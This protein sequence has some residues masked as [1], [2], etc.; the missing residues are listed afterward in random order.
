MRALNEQEIRGSLLN[1]SKREMAQASLPDLS[2]VAWEREIYLGWTDA[3]RPQESYVVFEDPES[4]ELLGA[5]LRAAPA[6][7]GR[8]KMMC[9][10]C[11]DITELDN[12]AFVSAKRTGAAGRS[13]STI[14]TSL[15]RDFSCSKNVRPLPSIS[16]VSDPAEQEWWTQRRIADLQQKIR[17]FFV[18]LRGG[19]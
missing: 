14:G 19:A 16:E 4:G 9:S 11:Q 1:G 18:Q 13:G 12:V 15:C 3:K 5:I 6:P 2:A 17:G 8:R 7:A 10:W